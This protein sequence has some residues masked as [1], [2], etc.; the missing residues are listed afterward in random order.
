MPVFEHPIAADRPAS[1]PDCGC[2]S[3]IVPTLNEAGNIDELLTSIFVQEQPNLKFEVLIADGGSTDG[4]AARV[5]A[6]EGKAAVRLVEC[7]GGFGLA[8]DV[9]QAARAAG[10]SIVVVMD[11]DLSHPAASIPALVAPVRN[12]SSDMVVASR[13]TEGGST[14]DWPWARRFLSR[15]GGLVA[16]PFTDVRDPM[17]GFFAVR[18]NFLINVDPNAAGF[19]IGLEV[20]AAAGDGIRASEIP[21]AFRDRE[22]GTSKIGIKQFAHFGRRLMVLAGGA[23]SIGTASRFASVGVLGIGV[24]YAMFGALTALGQSVLTAHVLSFICAT[25]F[26]YTLN[27]RWSFEGARTANAEPEW[28]MYGRFAA[29]SLMALFLRGGVIA[30]ATTVWNWPQDLALLLGIATGAAVNYFGS[31]FYIFPPVGTRI[32]SSVRWRIA[33]AGVAGYSLA[34]RIV[35]MRTLNLIPEEAYYWNYAQHLDIGYLDHPPMV[36]WLIWL[37][38]QVLG[39]NEFAVRLSALLLSLVTAVF[40]FQMARNLYGKTAAFVAVLLLSALPFFFATGFLMMPDAPLTAAWAGTLYFAERA[41]LAERKKAWL[42]LGVT[43]GLGLLSKYSIALLGPALLLFMAVDPRARAWLQTLWPYGA[44]LI[45][46]LIFSPVIFWNA[47][48]DWASFAFQGSRRLESTLQFSLHILVLSMIGLLTPIGLITAYSAIRPGG[49]VSGH[50]LPFGGDRRWLFIAIFSLVPLSVFAA[51]SLFH[52]VKLNWT[53]PLWLA[54]L[55]AIAAIVSNKGS[56]AETP[57]LHLQSNWEATIAATLV[58]FGGCLHYIVLGL[59]GVSYRG[60]SHLRDL[61]VA[62]RE[63]GVSAGRISKESQNADDPRPMMVGM[64]RYFIA[65]ELAFYN[66]DNGGPQQSAGRS[67][68]GHQSLMYDYWFLPAQ[69]NLRTMV[70]FSFKPEQLEGA[71]LLSH[72]SAFGP[73]KTEIVQREGRNLGTFYYRVGYKYRSGGLADRDAAAEP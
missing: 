32:S 67:L 10:G 34:L 36:A 13:Y 49:L 20:I 68:F 51:F 8:G 53:G 27:S 19:K 48:H 45:A 56:C 26:N 5:R 44:A 40:G 52:E 39:S 12:G 42:G 22:H 60:G 2:I 3:I 25:I 31:A 9:L 50:G 11:G 46:L 47:S 66:R 73:I 28:R 55:P 30:L 61:P 21:I 15:L 29:V 65:S 1:P 54:V 17:S 7:D 35:Y 71:D 6:W 41:L 4:T 16:W 38:T 18:R 72:F 33:A 63:F 64:D 23:V 70:L 14:P 58:I 59:P 69:Q 37:S 62:W 24:D 57:R 43:L